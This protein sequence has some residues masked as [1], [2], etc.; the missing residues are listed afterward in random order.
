[1]YHSQIK[2]LQQ[3][4]QATTKQMRIF[5]INNTFPAVLKIPQKII[6]IISFPENKIYDLPVQEIICRLP[7]KSGSN[8]LKRFGKIQGKEESAG[9]QHF[10]LFPYVD[11]WPNFYGR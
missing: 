1:M 2:I 9:H 11:K 10:L 4:T 6:F 5:H 3:K 7:M 8:Y